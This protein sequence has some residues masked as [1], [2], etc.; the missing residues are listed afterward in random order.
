MNKL[1]SS[2]KVLSGLFLLLLLLAPQTGSAQKDSTKT[3]NRFELSKNLDVF[4]AL[5]KEV[6]MF[7]VDTVDVE[8][9]VRR[10]IDAMLSGLD[11]YTEYIPEQ[12]MVPRLCRRRE[13]RVY[14]RSS[15]A[16]RARN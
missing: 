6:E 7:Y 9:T 3:D 13:K 1:F 8:K 5:V 11:P 2:N 12:E 16:R 4:N 14:H 10:G 15:Q